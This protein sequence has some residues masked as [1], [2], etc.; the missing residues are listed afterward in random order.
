MEIMT[1]P[2]LYAILD[3]AR[4]T[5]P[6][7]F[8]MELFAGGVRLLQLRDKQ[9]Q[10]RRTLSLARELRR[11]A[12]KDALLIMNDRPD[13]AMEA[14]FSGVHVGQEDISVAG[15]RRICPPPMVVGV[16]SHNPAQLQAADAT[17]ADYIAFGPIFATASKA[18]PDPV[19]G[20]DALRQSRT[21]TRKPLVAIGGVT[22][23]NCRAVV[24]AGA[25]SL[26]LISALCDEPRRQAAEFL[27]ILA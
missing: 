7:E 5:E 14:K 21:L 11:I 6:L 9:D 13:L 23:E 26:A 27:R 18:K 12:P 20:L 16:S 24:E 8:A 25:D 2:R 10:P 4:C 22:L 19:T 17:N 3:T 1:L 15:A